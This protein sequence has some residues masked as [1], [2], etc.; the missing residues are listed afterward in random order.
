MVLLW[1]KSFN[2]LLNY[3]FQCNLS[4]YLTS[5]SGGSHILLLCTVPHSA[6]AVP[7]S[8]E[9]WHLV[10]GVQVPKSPPGDVSRVWRIHYCCVSVPEHTGRQEGLCPRHAA[11]EAEQRHIPSPG[12]SLH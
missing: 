3:L 6:P 1:R 7:C 9:F 12:L 8:G 4:K 5:W 2:Q 10:W 11:P